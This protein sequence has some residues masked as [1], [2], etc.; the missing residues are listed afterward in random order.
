MSKGNFFQAI[1]LVACF[2]HSVAVFAEVEISEP[3]VISEDNDTYD[4]QDVVID[5]VEVVLDGYHEFLSLS[6]ING[7]VLTH[8]VE[9]RIDIKVDGA[10][11]IDSE[12][13]IDVGAK[14]LLPGED[15]VCCVAGSHGGRGGSYPNAQY[16]EELGVYI[17]SETSLSYGRYDMP[18][19]LGEGATHNLY[20]DDIGYYAARGAG[21]VK[22]FA[23]GI[24]LQGRISAGGPGSYD[25]RS[26]YVGAGGSIWLDVET[27]TI[28]AGF[29]NCWDCLSISAA[30][31]NGTGG[32]GGGR[33]AIYFESY[34]YESDHVSVVGGDESDNFRAD[35][36]GSGT[37]YLYDKSSQR[38]TLIV[39]EGPNWRGK[40]NT[41]VSIEPETINTIEVREG[42]VLELERFESLLYEGM[43]N[44]DLSLINGGSLIVD[45]DLSVGP[46]PEESNVIDPDS[47]VEPEFDVEGGRLVVNGRF[48]VNSSLV[49]G[50]LEAV[51]IIVNESSKFSKSVKV[52]NLALNQPLTPVVGAEAPK[53]TV[54]DS[55]KTPDNSLI[56]DGY[57]FEVGGNF[58]FQ[59]LELVNEAVLTTVLAREFEYIPI[60]L[61][62]SEMLIDETSSVDVAS[63]GFSP[64]SEA[65][66]E[67]DEYCTDYKAP[68]CPGSGY[69]YS[70]DSGY[71]GA[72]AI[73][74]VVNKLELNG[75]ISATPSSPR[76]GAGSIWLDVNHLTSVSGNGSIE[77][78]SEYG[79]S[80]LVAIYYE[81]NDGF[82]FN[83]INVPSGP[84]SAYSPSDPAGTIYLENKNTGERSLKL[85]GAGDPSYQLPRY[86]ADVDANT[87]VIVESANVYFTDS[88]QGQ[89]WK[90]SD[91]SLVTF[92]QNTDLSE[93]S[94][95]S[96][97]TSELV[98][99]GVVSLPLDLPI[100]GQDFTI[101]VTS[102]FLPEN[103]QLIVD[104]YT[105]S[106]NGEHQFDSVSVV[107]GGVITT[108]NFD[109]V[110]ALSISAN[111][112]YIDQD[113][114]IDLTGKGRVQQDGDSNSVGGSHGGLGGGYQY[115]DNTP[116][117]SMPTYGDKF[118]PTSP[119]SG[120]Y[121][122]IGGGVLKLSATNFEL[123][124]QLVSDG[125]TYVS[126]YGWTR[127]GSAGGS[128]LLDVENFTVSS[129]SAAISAKGSDADGYG[130]GGG[131]RVAVYYDNLTENYP[132][133]TDVSGGVATGGDSY[134]TYGNGEAGTAHIK[135]KALGPYVIGI[136]VK[137]VET[138]PTESVSVQFSEAI[139]A[140]SLSAS[141]MSIQSLSGELLISPDQVTFSSESLALF[142]LSEPLPD[143]SYRLVLEPNLTNT[144]GV[145]LD[146]N[147]NKISGEVPQDRY[148]F[149]F[150]LDTVAPST[151]VLNSYPSETGN[152]DIV[153]SGNK[154]IDS[155]LVINGSEYSNTDGESGWSHRV[156]LYPG[157]NVYTFMLVD[158]AGNKSETVVVTINY[159]SSIGSTVPPKPVDRVQWAQ[160]DGTRV[161]LDWGVYR[162]E[163]NENSISGYQIYY[164]DQRFSIPGDADGMMTVAAGVD[165]FE[166]SDLAPYSTV[167][168]V[169]VAVDSQ[170]L[171]SDFY[172]AKPI[173]LVDGEVPGRVKDLQVTSLD[174]TIRLSWLPSDDHFS[175]LSHY[176]VVVDFDGSYQTLEVS[177]EDFESGRLNV[178]IEGL[179]PATS[180][181]LEVRSVNGRGNFLEGVS[182]PG[183][184]LLNNPAE[185]TTS[186][187]FTVNWAAEQP[188]ELVDFY[189]IYV[190]E[191]NFTN[192]NSLDPLQ[193]IDV[194]EPDK[195]SYSASLDSL[196]Q[197]TLYYLTVIATN[198]SGGSSSAISVVSGSW[199]SDS[200]LPSIDSIHFNQGGSIKDIFTVP[201]LTGQGDL[202]VRA[203][204]ESGIA[205]I[206]IFLDDALIGNLVPSTAYDA[207]VTLPLDVYNLAD[208]EHSV[209]VEAFDQNGNNYSQTYNFT[210]LLSAP[211]PPLLSPP[212]E[213]I[214]N[215]E[216]ILIHGQ[217]IPGASVRLSVNQSPAE[218]LGI[219]GHEGHF[220]QF[221]SLSAGENLISAES[222]F[223]Q[224][225]IWSAP[226]S[227]IVITRDNSVPNAPTGLQGVAVNGGG[228]R[229]SWGGAGGDAAGYNVYRSTVGLTGP[230]LQYR[231][232]SGVVISKD[233]VD[234][235]SEDGIYTYGVTA[236][237]E[238][239]TE[240]ALSNT[241][242]ISVDS[243][244]PVATQ[245][246][247]GF[248]GVP[249]GDLLT[250]SQGQL[251]IRV[252]F[253][254]P[255]RNDPYL[256]YRASGSVLP[257][258]VDLSQNY[259][260]ST[261]YE[262]SISIDRSITSGTYYAIMSAYDAA[263]NRG[264]QILAGEV[265]QVD[266][267]GPDARSFA[268]EPGEPIKID[269]TQ[270]VQ[271]S[272]GT[273]EAVAEGSTPV[274]VPLVDGT[275]VSDYS[276]G[277]E[278]SLNASNGIWSG[279][280]SL[281]AVE[282]LPEESVATLS[283]TYMAKDE[284]NNV[285]SRI[286]GKSSYQIY[287][288]DLPPANIPQRLE[289]TSQPEGR[290]SLSWSPEP[291][292]S[293][294][295]VYRRPFGG[296]TFNEVGAPSE[297]AFVDLP[298]QDGKYEYVVSSVRMEN[299]QQAES[300]QSEPSVAYSDRVP[301]GK[302]SSLELSLT[303]GGVLATWVGAE[304]DPAQPERD[305]THH[306]LYRVADGT[307]DAPALSEL[308][309]II[310][311]IV[312]FI[313]LDESP[314]ND[315]HTYLVS[316]LD[317][318]GN[319][320]GPSNLEYLN[321]DLLP[322]S[323][324]SVAISSSG[325]AQL[326]WSHAGD[327]ISRF[328]LLRTVGEVA[329]DLGSINYQQQTVEFLDAG[330]QHQA[331]QPE[332]QYSVAA[333]DSNDVSS[334][335]NTLSIPRLTITPVEPDIQLSRGVFNK[336]T[337]KVANLGE[338]PLSNIQ[339]AVDVD[340]NG[341]VKSHISDAVSLSPGESKPVSV[342][343]GGYAKLEDE[344][345]LSVRV[346]YHP[347]LSSAISIERI[348]NA[349]VVTDALRFSFNVDEL[350]R[351][352]T[353]SVS[354]TLENTSD[355][356]VEL[357]MAQADG[358]NPSEDVS[359]SLEDSEGNVL[360][361]VQAHQY[362]GDV[363]NVSGG[364]IVARV[365][366]GGSFTSEA[367]ELP[368]PLAAPEDIKLRLSVARYRL[369]TGKDSELSIE[370]AG[371]VKTL[372]LV[373][374]AYSAQVDNVTPEH[375]YGDEGVQISGYA[376]SGT[377]D[378][379]LP[380]VPVK[381]VFS[382][383][384]FEEQAVVFTDSSGKFEYE[385]QSNGAAGIYTVSALH[386]DITTRPDHGGFVVVGASAWPEEARITIPRNYE[387]TVPL[388]VTAS[389]GAVIRNV[390]LRL[391][392]AIGQDSPE[393]PTGVSLSHYSI[394][395]IPEGETRL[396]DIKMYG[397]NSATDTGTIRFA[398]E[399]DNFTGSNAIGYLTLDYRLSAARPSIVASPFYIDT[400]VT[401]GGEITEVF[402]LQN[403]G[404][405]TLRNASISLIA[406]NNAAVPAW[407]SLVS[408]TTLG[409]ISPSAQK[410]V[411]I[412]LAPPELSQVGNY[413]FYLKVEGD[414]SDTQE[415]PVFVTVT[416]SRTGDAFFHAA[417]IYT[418]TL[419]ADGQL[420]EGLAGAK[421]SL[422][423]EQVLS[424]TFDLTTN[425][426]GEA[427]F[428]GIPAGRYSYRASAF[429]HESVSG[430]VWIKPGVTVTEKL[431]LQN[432]LINVEW[433]VTE[434]PIEDRYEITLEATY[435]TNV[436]AAVVLLEPLSIN[437][438]VM[439]KGQVYQGE[440]TL[441]N[442]GLVRAINVKRNID[443]PDSI[444]KIEFLRE[445]PSSLEAGE[446]IVLPYR[447]EAVR[448]FDVDAQDLVTGAGCGGVSGGVNVNY[449]YEC[450]SESVGSGNA[451]T[452]VNSNWGGSGSAC[453]GPGGYTGGGGGG[454][455]GGV[456]G[457][458]G[459]IVRGSGDSYWC[460]VVTECDDG[461]CDNASAK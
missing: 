89:A 207:E 223:A 51:D 78:V 310:D 428:E 98:L 324:F 394:D 449:Q 164:S 145:F 24:D 377:T 443:F 32:S 302:P 313:A 319:E 129:D 131:G 224:R 163:Q 329:T 134:R 217:T 203:S 353:A 70:H 111:D 447:I 83:N 291:E 284:F 260:D 152:R 6:L 100:S 55:I 303:G 62:F 404:A 305:K 283:F 249:T 61:T 355:T 16:D 293:G 127:G 146:Q 453:G 271:I 455:G 233:F 308:T 437:L 101:N 311:N 301:P 74:L 161:V 79:S 362:T 345:P 212:S 34:E 423:N 183:V 357:L 295:V 151:P 64:A 12:S 178:D 86:V 23:K 277:I 221:V 261:V 365:P 56:I 132:L 416:D 44:V 47:R 382:V 444:M 235:V 166:L 228:V 318:A 448:D 383:K 5:G 410:Q 306:R 294:Y 270:D 149:E 40:P 297:A 214:T 168:V 334:L 344:E 346:I 232:N 4:N 417:D 325:V 381:L 445:A 60:E 363:I 165:S 285:S 446:R 266:T 117:A 104:K 245:I 422:Q 314:A 147:Q 116:I 419:N 43:L 177:P 456:Y 8:S 140:A 181:P 52:N 279:N 137:A 67:P 289:A 120:G 386:P 31:S 36:G 10:V 206:H 420:I 321:I 71:Y 105:L 157:E 316:A 397:D 337:F 204:G 441:T 57:I 84:G 307:S 195:T 280:I 391:L 438:P 154:E 7:A 425:A 322:V 379:R 459:Y 406:K 69:G 401:L 399:A 46:S 175:N 38:G 187:S 150:V 254:E 211:E 85:Q 430:R 162:P 338:Q 407:A 112:I 433:S 126:S 356:D 358:L 160:G 2:F 135:Q 201:E 458:G 275:V 247:Y 323:N 331:G 142:E 246:E 439:E 405:Q 380:T 172:E 440:L 123:D 97:S 435:E 354:F 450:A 82:D 19:S 21:R 25:G 65:P 330:F 158:D 351:G 436:P 429:D 298:P 176:D 222:S 457:P 376:Y 327:T 9:N 91:N 255:L 106:L 258:V 99:Q 392:P 292:A 180:Y 371:L 3:L 190:S 63:R 209:R 352:G 268:L 230:A 174:N 403:M 189:E 288:G 136:D 460:R 256:A 118:Q 434:I 76:S 395:E 200:S 197:D 110:G 87:T 215:K 226:S 17:P 328:N 144:V 369:N 28:D 41:I 96:L 359:L 231:V 375:L 348:Y 143:G 315:E 122:G 14:G 58:Q 81:S 413:E 68:Q 299:E 264:T 59:T 108:Q 128:I 208:G 185:I 250:F 252:T 333:I 372:R 267:S 396:L 320:S 202:I 390:R 414:N 92:T 259:Q 241:V 367:I 53:L 107:N 384:G 94:G 102:K 361:E 242:E 340:V 415:F 360:S 290:V 103:D 93:F 442:Y 188:S 119:G 54:I 418:A 339:V 274:V 115:R 309:P 431:F 213:V 90:V 387:Q 304:L 227:A 171:V 253:D 402:E 109:D 373:D 95:F 35:S 452:S 276:Q 240:S 243:S 153:L 42:G 45:G 393:L 182:N 424:E 296:A 343:V 130:G 451:K 378:N 427:L 364:Y 366:P 193:R 113:S 272:F 184:T 244:G 191:Q 257:V 312:G 388:E 368:I 332:V 50:E 179:D 262:G 139:A 169:I 133:V 229:L 398:I 148:Q 341:E 205:Y 198:L 411:Q 155:T 15:V 20:H 22:I 75:K 281:N 33:V 88:Y 370:G 412:K 409:D 408:T 251:G 73:K 194:T 385:Y 77:A 273:S 269:V 287:G 29:E 400:G 216:R 114:R 278:L 263:G 192:I 37:L 173:L 13:M 237:N 196:S 220:S 199:E 342:M 300:A 138:E 218:G 26:G 286:D 1:F 347:S 156:R 454:G 238:A 461:N 72:G 124:G 421:I 432:S 326:S 349:V 170:G 236:L 225:N 335:A 336:V 30:G 248:E 80:G 350:V 426:L 167:Y 210:V 18:D 39:S 219:A 125:W 389:A 27:L 11:Y 374:A 239:G 49:L 234:T 66:G 48:S 121:E 186:D 141:D 282:V 317:H 265:I 159:D